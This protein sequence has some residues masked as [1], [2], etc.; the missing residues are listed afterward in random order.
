MMCRG[1][2]LQEVELNLTPPALGRGPN[3]ASVLYVF[4]FCFLGPLQHMEVPRRGVE[5]EL[6]LPAYATATATRDLSCVW[7]PHRSSL[8]TQDP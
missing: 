7:D 1:P 4:I 2:S 5:L 3:F 6:P 8:A